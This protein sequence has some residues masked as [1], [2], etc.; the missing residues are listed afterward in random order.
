MSVPRR[1]VNVELNRVTSPVLDLSRAIPAA[2]EVRPIPVP[3]RGQIFAYP[4]D[5]VRFGLRFHPAARIL[6]TN[7]N[8]L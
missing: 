4:V 2:D 5:V 3:R 8:R 6:R 7:L 1:L